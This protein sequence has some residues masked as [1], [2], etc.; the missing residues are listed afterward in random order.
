[1]SPEDSVQDNN[2]D[3]FFIPGSSLPHNPPSDSRV[4]SSSVNS[5]SHRKRTRSFVN[6]PERGQLGKIP[7]PRQC[8]VRGRL[9]TSLAPLD[10]AEHARSVREDTAELATYILSDKRTGRSPS[11]LSRTRSGSSQ[12]GLGTTVAREDGDADAGARRV[13]GPIAEVSEPPSP[14]EPAEPPHAPG[15]SLLASMLRKYPL[16]A[17]PRTEAED[18][19]SRRIGE[20]DGQSLPV[21]Q[22][23]EALPP[24]A[25]AA[26]GEGHGET[27]PLLH[28]TSRETSSV[29][30]ASSG[31]DR[32]ADLE[33]QKIQNSSKWL[34]SLAGYGT[35]A[36][37][38]LLSGARVASDPTRWN[39]R[40]LWENVV[41]RPVTCL[42][43]V[44]VGLLLNIL[45]ALS[46]GRY[47][48]H[49]PYQ[50]LY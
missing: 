33:S 39:H 26:E 36:K 21:P 3:P 49:F 45:D 4:L 2:D 43:A 11:F 8:L 1:M 16:E 9:L 47:S 15:P 32:I 27:T 41:V 35:H 40:T 14:G 30:G 46:Y 18:A 31:A 38:G 13:S 5:G 24:P 28:R 7:I 19:R 25:G 20:E 37:S 42:P 34:T 12:A 23:I 17:D 44:V 22:D 48:T 50:E 6:G 10:T 29:S